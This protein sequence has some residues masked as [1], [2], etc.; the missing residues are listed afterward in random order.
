MET[1][2]LIACVVFLAA[3]VFGGMMMLG[4]VAEMVSTSAHVVSTPAG[5][6]EF[7]ARVFGG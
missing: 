6:T 1:S 5:Q 7:W 3:A 4:E 2:S